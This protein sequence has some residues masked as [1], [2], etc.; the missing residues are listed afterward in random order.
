MTKEKED[1]VNKGVVEVPPL[2][3]QPIDTTELTRSL[4]QVSLKETEIS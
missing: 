3:S 1:L 4:A 2:T